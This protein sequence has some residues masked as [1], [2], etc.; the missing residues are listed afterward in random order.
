VKFSPR[1]GASFF[2]A[3]GGGDLEDAHLFFPTLT[4]QLA[5]SRRTLRPHIAHAA[6]EYLQPDGERQMHHAFERLQSALRAALTIDQPPTFLVVD[7]ID[8]CRDTHLVPDLLQYL[9]VLVRQLP[10]LYVLVASRP[11]PRILSVLASSSSANVV[12]HIRLED[13]LED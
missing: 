1:L 4:Y 9:L 11:E 10:W 13:M 2:F 6:Q 8:E 5:L 12:H 7:G 3:R